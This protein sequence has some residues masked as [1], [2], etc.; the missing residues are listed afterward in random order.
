MDCVEFR[1]KITIDPGDISDQMQAHQDHCDACRAYA[2]RASRAE[3]L[4]HAA[5]R[6]DTNL[7]DAVPQAPTASKQMAWTG[8]AA[9]IIVA[10]AGWFGLQADIPAPTDELV[11]EVVA[12][13]NHEPDS[14]AVSNVSVPTHHLNMVLADQAA[15][16][17]SDIGLVTYASSCQV[18]GKWMPH[19]VVQ[20]DAGPVM[21]LLIPQQRVDSAVSLE[22]PDT[23]FSGIIMPSG[24][25]SLAIIGA[26]GDHFKPVERRIAAAI[27]LSI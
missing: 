4:I 1:E 20:S 27:E 23:G 19:L 7:I 26:E 5:L 10:I 8:I 15:L 22:L 6:F 21:L 9:A 2:K 24:A 13:W 12:H 17:F 16:D 25:G 18:A 14:W 3:H 11:A